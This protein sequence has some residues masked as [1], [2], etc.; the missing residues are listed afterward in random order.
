M[1]NVRCKKIHTGKTL[2]NRAYNAF[3][4]RNLWMDEW[5]RKNNK[6]NRRWEEP[7]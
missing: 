2:G 4:G 7:V 6:E 3:S 5:L 1:K